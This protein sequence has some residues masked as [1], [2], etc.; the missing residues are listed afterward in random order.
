MNS[1]PSD[2]TPKCLF[3]D[4][5]IGSYEAIALQVGSKKRSEKSG[6]WYFNPEQF[7]DDEE[8]KWFHL[9]CMQQV[10]DFSNAPDD[11][12][13]DRDCIFCGAP[14]DREVMYFE[15]QLGRFVVEGNDTIFEHKSHRVFG[16]DKIVRSYGCYDCVFEGL[17]EGDTE[18]ARCILG[19]ELT[20]EPKSRSPVS[21]RSPGIP[22]RTRP[23]TVP[24]RTAM[25]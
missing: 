1:D 21:F 3:C 20:P 14:L 19:M 6:R 25:R 2:E 22:T 11:P 18:L 4:N 17:G 23:E 5:Q 10:F 15:F 24:K 9:H 16:I 7:D 12:D 13:D 8:V